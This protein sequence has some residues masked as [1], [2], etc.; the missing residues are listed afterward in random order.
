[1]LFVL[2]ESPVLVSDLFGKKTRTVLSCV[3][4][5]AHLL[6]NKLLYNFVVVW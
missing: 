1:M 6:G 2:R 4:H 3:K 5:I